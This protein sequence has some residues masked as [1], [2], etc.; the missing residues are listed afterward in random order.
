MPNGDRL[1]I[2]IHGVW[3]DNRGLQNLGSHCTQ[4]LPGLKLWHIN[5]G[6]QGP[7]RVRD[8][9]IRNLIYKTVTLAFYNLFDRLHYQGVLTSTKVYIVAHSFGTIALWE[10]LRSPHPGL[11][12]EEIVLLGSIL[13][14][15]TDWD[16]VFVRNPLIAL[17][18]PINFVRP[19]DTIVRRGH[20]I[21]NER[22]TSGTR[23]F[24]ATGANIPIDYFK[25][26]GHVDYDPNDF[27]DIQTIIDGSFDKNG[28]TTREQ[29]WDNLT[30]RQ[31]SKL[32]ALRMAKLA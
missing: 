28:V 24:S 3:S 1:L 5:Y 14:Q 30:L 31:K 22:A 25:M 23:G 26:G 18:L 32:R 7:L 29:F 10:Y 20:H 12:F 4:N 21:H 13:P 19:F 9:S 6:S 11:A 15:W 2:T 27:N 16:P 8:G 17:N